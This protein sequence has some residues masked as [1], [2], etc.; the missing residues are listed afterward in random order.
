MQ[1]IGYPKA[2]EPQGEAQGRP[3]EQLPETTHPRI[4][5]PNRTRP[6]WQSTCLARLPAL[7]RP[8]GYAIH[9]LQEHSSDAGWAGMQRQT[10]KPLRSEERRVGKEGRTR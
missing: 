6:Q 2:P 10:G 7:F 4:T 1:P 9:A 5:K 8:A 3:K